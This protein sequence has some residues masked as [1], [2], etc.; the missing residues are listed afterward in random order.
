ME[1]INVYIDMI[2]IDN[3]FEILFVVFLILW[4]II[5]IMEFW[6]YFCDEF[7]N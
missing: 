6:I 4:E 5:K 2:V 3:I 1:N 7:L